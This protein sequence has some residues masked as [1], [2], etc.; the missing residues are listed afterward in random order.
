MTTHVDHPAPDS[1]SEPPIARISARF[2]IAFAACQ[3]AVMVAM[4]AFVLPQGGDPGDPALTRGRS[5]L[6][7]V[8]AYRVGNYAFMVAGVLLLGS[9]GVVPPRLRRVD[10]TGVLSAVALASG[11]L[12]AL[13]WP[14][15]GALHDVALDTAVAGTDPR[16]LAG[17]DSVA[18]FAL[19]FS[20]LVRVFFVGSLVLGLR[21]AGTAPRL[22][23]L[24]LVLIPVSLVGSATLL[25][26]ALFPLLA[27]GTLGYELWVA[28]V[29][30]HWLRTS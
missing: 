7:A 23:R 22:Q 13:I 11:T 10:T 21:L 16:I 15:A 12:L 2:G 20:A 29:A 9:S 24:G 25:T 28:A 19:A 8:T 5:V 17:W 27:L 3:L 18:P 14:F 26:G 30:W 6:D 4:A 1:T